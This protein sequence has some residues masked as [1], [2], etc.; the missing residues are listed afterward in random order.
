MRAEMATVV[1]G[2]DAP[3][4]NWPQAAGPNNNWA[5]TKDQTV[6]LKSSVEKNENIR[7]RLT[8]AE[9]GQSGIVVWGD[10]LFLNT[11]KPLAAGAVEKQGTDNLSD[12]DLRRAGQGDARGD[13]QPA[14]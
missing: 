14:G 5:V 4:A 10:R 2:V 1:Y 7:W 6:P 3:S 8:Q 11:M 9:S 12:G 13:D